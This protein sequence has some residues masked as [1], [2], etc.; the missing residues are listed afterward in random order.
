MM[1]FMEKKRFGGLNFSHS[2]YLDDQTLGLSVT[3]LYARSGFKEPPL[4]NTLSG[5]YPG[6]TR[7]LPRTTPNRCAIDLASI[8]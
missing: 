1:C 6:T 5:D 8:L 7:E 3:V 2:R 4:L